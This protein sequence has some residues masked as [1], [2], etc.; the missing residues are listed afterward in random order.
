MVILRFLGQS[1]WCALFYDKNMRRRYDYISCNYC[2]YDTRAKNDP[3]T[4]IFHYKCS[5]EINFLTMCIKIYRDLL[6]LD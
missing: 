1:L 3:Y 5:G 4:V 2:W 6:Y